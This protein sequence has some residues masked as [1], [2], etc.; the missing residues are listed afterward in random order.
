MIRGSATAVVEKVMPPTESV[1]QIGKVT[2]I[3]IRRRTETIKP[4]VIGSGIVGPECVVRPKR[5]KY[6]RRQILGCNTS[7][8][9]QRIGG[10]VGRT[11]D[12]DV[13]LAENALN[14]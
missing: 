14:R 4:P 2:D 3:H 5:W 9:L 1:K 11:D 7:M 8:I 6:R 13:E 12:T 10:I